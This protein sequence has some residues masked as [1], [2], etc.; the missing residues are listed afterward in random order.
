[1]VFNIAN[2]AKYAVQQPTV[3]VPHSL[4]GTVGA[5]EIVSDY[6]EGLQ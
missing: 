2:V 4:C 1:M 6:L 5:D 3:T